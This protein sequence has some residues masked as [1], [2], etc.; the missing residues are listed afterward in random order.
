MGLKIIPPKSF[1]VDFKVPN[2]NPRFWDAVS[3]D[4]ATEIMKRTE[5]QGLDVND[6]P[7]RPYTNRY[8]KAKREGKVRAEGGGFHDPRGTA[9]VSLSLSGRML[10]ALAT[11]TRHG[12]D[13]AKIFL[14]GDDGFKAWAN[15]K[16]GR[17]FMG[18]SSKRL[19]KIFKK[20]D[21]WIQRTNK[22]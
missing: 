5:K 18:L 1:K 7:F 12:K 8:A 17:E 15:E 3:E 21:G 13:F 2:N 4:I 10:E 11:G 20:I 14:S 9:R 16:N 22:L 19:I 6:R